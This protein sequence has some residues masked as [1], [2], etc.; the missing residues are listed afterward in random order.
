MKP[1]TEIEW[2]IM[3][4]MMLVIYL[5]PKYHPPKEDKIEKEEIDHKNRSASSIHRV[6]A[7]KAKLK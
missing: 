6:A 7:I 4:G 5:A 1:L 2:L 3:L